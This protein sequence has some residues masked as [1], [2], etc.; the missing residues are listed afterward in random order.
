MAAAWAGLGKE[1][2]DRSYSDAAL[3]QRIKVYFLQQKGSLARILFALTLIV[4]ADLSQPL[5]ISQGVTLVANNPDLK[6]LLI[7]AGSVY[8]AAIGSWGANVIRRRATSRAIANIVRQMRTDA[9]EAAVSRDMSFYDEFSS[10]K[11]VSRIT[12]DTQ[13]FAQMIVLVTD[14]VSQM[15]VLILLVTILFF[16]EW[17]L[18]LMLMIMV[19]LVLGSALMYRRIAREVSRQASRMLANVNGNIQE[20]VAGISV[21]KNFRQERT[22]YEQFKAVNQQSYKVNLRRGLIIGLVY[23]TLHILAA[24]G[25]ASLLYFG[26]QSVISGAINAGSWFLFLQSV[27]KF[28]DPLSGVASF[29]SQFQAGLAS[30]ERIFAL[31]DASAA[32]QQ[33]DNQPVPEV[34]GDIVFDHLRFQY[35]NK[36]I[37]LP[38][39]DLHIAPGETIAF[40]GHTGAGKS[41]IA[42]LIE[43]FYEFQDGRLLIDGRDIR[44]LNLAEFRRHLGIVSQTPFLFSGTILDNIRYARPEATDAEI[45]RVAHSI[46][47][48]EWIAAMPQGLLTDVGERGSRLSMGQRQL[49]ALTRVLVQAPSIFIL[50]EATASIDPFTEAQI[51]QALNMILARSTSIL[52]AH[53]LSTVKSADRI[54]VLNHGEII[55]QGNHESLLQQ[56]G[57]YAELYNTYFRHQSLEYIESSKTA[58]KVIKR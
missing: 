13:D 49:V 42:K 34:R 36:E 35:S 37:V 27:Y 50:D 12:S 55:E 5:I 24:F 1:A 53:R 39:L 45:E 51:Q 16:T 3:I 52:I 33:T 21:A 43:R 6:V 46:G 32:V 25:N 41:S 4:L 10:G 30:A 28:W 2:Y 8:F 38:G 15:M 56:G 48:G 57:H 47:G 40:V 18:A 31:I 19:P 54:I 29:W 11:I 14:L 22:I 17:H 9:F 44:T 20:S 58:L 23:P 7:V 26:A